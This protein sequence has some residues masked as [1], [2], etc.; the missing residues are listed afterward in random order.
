[1]E[2]YFA[3]N[4]FIDPSKQGDE[5]YVGSDVELAKYIADKLGVK[6]QLVPLD[7]TTVLS[8]ITEGKYDLAIS[9]LAYTPARAEAMN[10]SK[11]YYF[12]KSSKGYGLIIRTEDADK[13]KS[14]AD[15][16]DKIVVAQ[17]G[18]IQ[19]LFIN[20]Q[21]PK[22]AEF[23]RVSSTYDAYLMVS[24]KKADAASTAISSG[25]LY[26]EANTGCGLMIVPDF[27]FTMDP[28]LDGTRIGMPLGEDELTDKI[29]EIIDEVRAQGL[30]DKW[31]DEYTEY[32]SKLGVK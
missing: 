23:K 19:E 9:A 3:P 21:V 27:K 24:E 22:Y 14:P 11:G 26:I 10:L 8:S 20:E 17:S 28:S 13:I 18:S 30:Y 31:Y 25:T 12:S 6:L 29:N 1:M 16:T 5:Q 7:F 32:A 2:P 4:E 15:L